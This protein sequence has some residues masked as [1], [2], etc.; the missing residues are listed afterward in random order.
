MKV[1]GVL[2]IF[3]NPS[4]QKGEEKDVWLIVK[5]RDG[6]VGYLCLDFDKHP[7][8]AEFVDVAGA[9]DKELARAAELLLADTTLA[10]NF[11][12]RPCIDD[13]SPAMRNLFDNME[14]AEAITFFDLEGDEEWKNLGISREEY[15]R[16]IDSD[17]QR[18]G[19]DGIICKYNDEDCLYTCYGDF[20]CFFAKSRG[21]ELSA[22]KQNE[23]SGEISSRAP[24]GGNPMVSV[25]FVPVEFQ[26]DKENP[27]R[28]CEILDRS[29]QDNSI[30]TYV[31]VRD[32]KDEA[33][34]TASEGKGQQ[35][36]HAFFSALDY[37]ACAYHD[38]PELAQKHFDGDAYAKKYYQIALFSNPA[39]RLRYSPIVLDAHWRHNAPD[40]STPNVFGD[41]LING[42]LS[43]HFIAEIES[44]FNSTS[45]NPN[46]RLTDAFLSQLDNQ[47]QISE[48]RMLESNA[49]IADTPIFAAAQYEWEKER[50]RQIFNATEKEMLEFL[51]SL[52][53]AI[54]KHGP[55]R[56]SLECFTDR[57][58]ELC[59]GKE[60]KLKEMGI[61]PNSFFSPSCNVDSVFRNCHMALQRFQELNQKEKSN[62]WHI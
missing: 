52:D 35:R 22:P 26:R 10:E 17:I 1:N 33:L 56:A 40:Y 18:Y 20:L 44:E 30:V 4:A 16:Q 59:V 53:V 36:D 57:L 8:F 41:S 50:T 46:F 3:R 47:P 7:A 13:A 2:D 9:S 37:I 6:R 49:G 43:P 14:S 55:T 31:V 19:L 21:M 32:G 45:E 58:N 38:S 28:I 54:E 29:N 12:E 24:D 23:E 62:I 15:E 48:V 11:S 5:D 25:G 27:F 34:F 60:D 61:C 42:E 39:T 51:S